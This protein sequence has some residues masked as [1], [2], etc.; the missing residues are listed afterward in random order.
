MKRFYVYECTNGHINY[1]E[2]GKEAPDCKECGLTIRL[3]HGV[4]VGA[5][6]EDELSNKPAYDDSAESILS[7]RITGN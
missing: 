3:I 5:E 7:A 1:V 6:S 2:R 4:T